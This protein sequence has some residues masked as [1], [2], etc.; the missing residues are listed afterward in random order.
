MFVAGTGIDLAAMIDGTD[1]L[2]LR[3]IRQQDVE[4]RLAIDMPTS[5][6]DIQVIAPADGVDGLEFD[7]WDLALIHDCEKA[8]IFHVTDINDTINAPNI[9]L[10]HSMDPTDVWRNSFQT[11]AIKNSFETDAVVTAIEAHIYYVS[12]GTGTNTSG[13]TPLSLW[14]KSGTGM[15]VELIEGIEDLQVLFGVSDDGDLTPNQ[16]KAANQVGD[17]NWGDVTT[18]RVTV[19]ANTVDD[20]GG[21]MSPTQTCDVQ[22]CYAGEPTGGIDGLMRRTF[23]QTIKLRN[24]S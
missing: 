21:T 15:P 19:V 3:N 5:R 16:Y 14:R 18:I 1:V 10:E 12:P 20:V 7:Q 24:R 23:T 8:T 4:I 2:T 17:A 11:L 22:T 9:T 6:E 13:D